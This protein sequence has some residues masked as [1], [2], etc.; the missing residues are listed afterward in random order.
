SDPVALHAEF[1]R[2]RYVPDERIDHTCPVL[3]H[4]A[5]YEAIR[6]IDPFGI[7]YLFTNASA[8]DA[9]LEEAVKAWARAKSLA[10][11]PKVTGSCSPLDPSYVSIADTTGGQALF[12]KPSEIND[13]SKLIDPLFSGDLEPLLIASSVLNG[14]SNDYTIAVDST[15]TS[16]TA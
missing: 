4:H 2:R 5:L 16:L 11:H 9:Q 1:L 10:I 14:G 12:M 8:K 15:I 13:V 3:T 6:V 7:L